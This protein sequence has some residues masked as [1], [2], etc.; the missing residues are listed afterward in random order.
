MIDFLPQVSSVPC[1]RYFNIS[2]PLSAASLRI[3]MG[4]NQCCSFP[5]LDQT[6]IV[7]KAA[8]VCLCIAD[9]HLSFLRDMVRFVQFNCLHGSTSDQWTLQG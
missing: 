1:F 9:R 4:E 6:G 3:D 8:H 5:W 2:R 7:D